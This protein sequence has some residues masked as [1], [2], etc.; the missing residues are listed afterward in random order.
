MNLYFENG[1]K[2]FNV[3]T[4]NRHNNMYKEKRQL[5]IM[6]KL[7]LIVIHNKVPVNGGFDRN[8]TVLNALKN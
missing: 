8:K 6:I 7:I 3:S 5:I 1:N 2:Y 4:Q